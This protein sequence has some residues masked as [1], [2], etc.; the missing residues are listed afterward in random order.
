MSA[1]LHIPKPGSQEAALDQQQLYD[2]GLQ[3]VQDL[4]SRLWTDYNVHDPGIT[5]L[6]LLCYALTDLGYRASFPIPDLL[7]SA[8]DNAEEMQKQFFS[9]G[10][11]L[12]SQPLTLLDYRKLLID[13]KGVKNAWLRP[14]PLTYYADTIN[15]KLFSERP[16]L[17][18]I[19][20]IQISGIYEVTIEYMDD[21]TADKQGA[22]KKNVMEVLQDNRN[23]CEDF[24][25]VIKEVAPQEFRL[26]CEVELDPKAEVER[27]M[28]EI[29]FKVQEYLSPPIHNYTLSEMLARKRPDGTPYYTVDEIFDGPRLECGFIDDE[30]LERAE[31]R[32]E[33]RLSDVIHVIMQIE[34]VQAVRDILINPAPPKESKSP[35]APP[36]NKWVLPVESGN[37][38]ILDKDRSRLVF[39]KRNMPVTCG[40][41]VNKYYDNF[42]STARALAETKTQNDLDIPLGRFRQVESY[43]SVQN[44]FPVVYGLSAS[45][46]SSDADEPRRALAYQ[47]K[48]YLL[49]F[50][51]IM[52]DYFAQLRQVKELF[53]SDPNLKHT[54]FCQVVDSFAD[55]QSIY[56]LKNLLTNLQ[57]AQNKDEPVFT[58]LCILQEDA[59]ATQ[60][61]KD[62]LDQLVKQFLDSKAETSEKADKALVNLLAFLL[63]SRMDDAEDESQLND[64]ITGFLQG[65]MADKGV[66][67]LLMTRLIWNRLEDKEGFL[68]RR[69]RFLDHLIARFAERFHDFA[70]IMYSAFK[71]S[72]ASLIARKCEFLQDYPAISSERSL[73]YNYRPS[74]VATLWDSDQ[75]LSGLEQRLGRLLGIRNYKR[76]NLA[77]IAYDSDKLVYGNETDGFRFRVPKPEKGFLLSSTKAY[78]SKEEALHELQ[79]TVTFGLL[80]SGYDHKKGADGYRFNIV[81]DKGEMMATRK[82][83]FSSEWQRDNAIDE[84]IEYLWENYSDEGM[85]VVE[86]LL[87]RPDLPEHPADPFLRVVPDPARADGAAEDPYSYRLHIILPAYSSRFSNMEFRRFAEEVIREETPAHILPKI[88]W[89][90]RDYLS[91]LEKQYRDW[92]YLKAGAE[93]S[94]R[95]NKLENFINTLFAVRNVYPTQRLQECLAGDPRDKFILGSTILGTKK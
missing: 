35:P 27:V 4:A 78:P 18:G 84:L 20:E 36:A 43:Y 88:C 52:A 40:D 44:H 29:L 90:D 86:N 51:Q 9:A 87:L 25:P 21:V 59:G 55:Y 17:P 2:I 16:N 39:Y 58:Q 72:P 3:H 37:K 61:D 7:A 41:Q 91:V 95:Q 30:E 54:Y 69:N 1:Q 68:E 48:A 82:E 38:P 62:T 13:L 24:N 85:F 81:D 14:A 74:N 45:G 33:I 70:E 76:R 42:I 19:K 8:S 32:S 64:L 49:F 6:E 93:T 75:N 11:I 15:A 63:Q 80:P 89:I 22:I 77:D 60:N 83:S 46:L 31:L 73:A 66:H 26:C 56:D 92:I 47:L 53:S 23:L 34:G 94:Q 57:K 65:Q 71:S 50:D 79:R 10:K 67:D 12:P 28:A 5:T